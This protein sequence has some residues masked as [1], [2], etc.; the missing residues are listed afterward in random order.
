M[1]TNLISHM[2]KLFFSL[3]FVAMSVM[4]FAQQWNA[5]SSNAPV[6]PEVTLVSSSE[7]QVVVDFSLGGFNLTKVNTPSGT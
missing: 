5:I 3:L 7:E 1:S 2:K 6:S 4:A